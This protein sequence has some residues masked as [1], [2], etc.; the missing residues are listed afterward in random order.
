MT[1]KNGMVL[2]I[3][4]IVAIFVYIW[5]RQKEDFGSSYARLGGGYNT[6]L[7]SPC[8]SKRC[9]GGPY[10]FTSDPYMQ[11]LCQGVTNSDLAQKACGKAFHGK[12]VH[13]DFTSLSNGAWDNALCNTSSPSSLCTL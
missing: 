6:Q 3:I 2:F 4:L 11:A 1:D 8:I 5:M 7:F 9:A 10:M 13:F 12:P